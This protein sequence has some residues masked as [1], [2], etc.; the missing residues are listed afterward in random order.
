MIIKKNMDKS[1][2]NY[3]KTLQTPLYLTN[4]ST[5]QSWTTS[6]NDSQDEKWKF[7]SITNYIICGSKL[8]KPS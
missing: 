5:L 6:P 7:K 4:S 2:I 8:F 1:I 3:S